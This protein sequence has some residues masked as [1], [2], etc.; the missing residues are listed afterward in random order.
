MRQTCFALLLL[1]S[2]NAAFAQAKP[3]DLVFAFYQ[4]AE[5]YFAATVVEEDPANKGQWRVIFEDGDSAVVAPTQLK[6]VDVK[7]GLE[8][9]AR[10][11][12]GK[13]YQGKVAKV[14]GRAVWIEYKD[15][16]KGWASMGNI[17]VK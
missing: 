10:W 5:A 13:F 16:D 8:V 12:D 1:L 6:T 14:V 9:F 17:A 2:A 7:E 3:G 4:K 11:K 15:G